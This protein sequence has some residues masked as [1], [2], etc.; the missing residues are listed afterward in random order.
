MTVP[1]ATRRRS[2]TDTAVG[3]GGRLIGRYGTIDYSVW[4]KRGFLLGFGLF[5]LGAIGEIAGHALL[6][7]MPATAETILFDFEVIGILLGL[8]GPLVFGI[9]LPLTEWPAPFGQAFT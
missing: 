1:I 5:A 7:T 3:V 2:E 8:F 9:G 4:A 6:G